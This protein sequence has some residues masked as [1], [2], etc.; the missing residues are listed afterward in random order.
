MSRDKAR[1]LLWRKRVY[2]EKRRVGG[3]GSEYEDIMKRMRE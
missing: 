3:E 1:L 2:E